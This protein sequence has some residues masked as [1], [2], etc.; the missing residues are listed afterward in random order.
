MSV[1]VI[2][3][4]IVLLVLH[5]L[6]PYILRKGA[7]YSSSNTKSV[8]WAFKLVNIKGKRL[9]DLGCGYGRV[10][11]IAK[12]MGANVTGIEIDPIRWFISL[13]R[14]RCRV[15]FGDMFKIDLS[16]YDVV[17]LFQWPSVNKKLARK[18]KKE[19]RKGTHVISYMWE[20]PG[21]ELVAYDKKLD[22]YIY[23]I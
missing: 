19:L 9:I 8:I 22:I 13:I 11:K 2:I 1:Q 4:A 16:N 21:L 17:Y 14:C 10:L 15:L 7:G 6:W 5:F 18:F 23:R 3:A 20:V 12:R